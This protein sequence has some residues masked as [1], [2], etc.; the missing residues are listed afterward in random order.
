VGPEVLVGVL[1]ERSVE[2]VVAVLGV[3][4]AGGAYVP[5]DPNYPQERLALMIE[6]IAA[7]VLLTQERHVSALAE[8]HARPLY[9]DRDQEQIAEQSEENPSPNTAAHN[10]A[11]VIFTSG[12]TGKP[13]GVLVEHQSLVNYVEAMI[14]RLQLAAGQSFAMVQPLTVDASLTALYPPLLTGGC[15]HV[16]SH[17]RALNAGYLSAYFSRHQIDCLKIAPSH[18]AALHSDVRAE[19]LMPRRWL[20]IGGEAS[21]QEWVEQLQQRAP[22]CRI[23]NHYGPTEAT[24]GMLTYLFDKDD[25]A[26][27]SQMVKTGRP[28]QNS[29]VYILDEKMRSLPVGVPGD[30]YLGGDCL[31]RGYLNRPGL[32]AEKFVPDPFSMKPGARLYQ[33]GDMA[34]YLPDGNVM[35]L[36]RADNQVKIRGFR[37]E[38]G[39]VMAALAQHPDVSETVVTAREDATG[40]KRLV[41]YVVATAGVQLGGQELRNFV[42]EKLPEYMIPSAFVQLEKLPKTSHG[43]LDLQALPSP[44]V[45]SFKIRDSFTRPRDLLELQLVQLWESILHIHPVGV[46]DNFFDLGGHS[47]SAVHLMA[48]VQSQFGQDIPLTDLFRGATVEHLASVLRCQVIKHSPSPLVRIQNSGNRQAFF[49]V[50]PVGGNVFCY[51]ELSRLL[52]P[53]QPFYGFQ[54]PGLTGEQEPLASIEEMAAT[55]VAALRQVQPQGPYLLGGWSLGGVVAFEMAQQMQRQ[56]EQV[57]LVALLD[58]RVPSTRRRLDEEDEATILAMFF[59]DMSGSSGQPATEALADAFVGLQQLRGEERLAYVL[60]QASIHHLIPP[61]TDVMHLRRLVNVFRSNRRALHSYTPQSYAGRTVLFRARDEEEDTMSGDRTLGWGAVAR[62]LE[63]VD[64][65]GYHYDMLGDPHAQQLAAHLKA[66]LDA[67][68]DVLAAPLSGLVT[69]SD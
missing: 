23:L 62:K 4:K 24:V 58:S 26:D 31:A 27:A 36:G 5:L 59:M 19:Q 69:S 56:G 15:V 52:G 39:E 30:L 37:I 46:T 57:S 65:P 12:S 10:L 60:K 2:L 8:H 51:L 1:M 22:S 45:D 16:I 55:Y 63:V 48:R 18:L 9:L 67:S 68:G 38:L 41:A 42:K 49:C 64:V 13:K 28:L 47:I 6:D 17:K 44:D 11:Y 3:L 14:S 21:Q 40:D 7:P 29:S 53:E 50:H 25:E 43:K 35:F 20:V 34:R 54:S 33:T 66:Y 32:T 61:Q